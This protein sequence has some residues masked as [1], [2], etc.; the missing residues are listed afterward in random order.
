MYIAVK[1]LNFPLFGVGLP[2][3]IPS[4]TPL[5]GVKLQVAG[6]PVNGWYKAIW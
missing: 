5:G 2:T 3:M 1:M 6:N 4:V